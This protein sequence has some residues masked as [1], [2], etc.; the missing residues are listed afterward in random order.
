VLEANIATLSNI[1]VKFEKDPF[2]VVVNP[3]TQ[4]C[5]KKKVLLTHKTPKKG[6]VVKFVYDLKNIY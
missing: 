6:R 4:F 1:V 2:C 3:Q 5:Q